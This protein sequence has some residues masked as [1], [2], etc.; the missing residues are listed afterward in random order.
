MTV[1]K[2]K[3][4]AKNGEIKEGVLMAGSKKEAGEELKDKQL[5]PLFVQKLD[6]KEGKKNLPLFSQHISLIEKANLCR[7]LSTMINS[8]L[9][10]PEAVEVIASE[11]THPLMEKILDDVRA[12]LQ[13]GQPLSSAFSKY[14]DV[15]DEVFLTLIKAGEE[16]GTLGKSFDYLGKQLYADYELTSKVKSTLA[17]PTVIVCASMGLGVAMLVFVVPQIAP[18]L[19]NLNKEFPLPFYTLLILQTGLFISQKILFFLGILVFLAIML[20][21][22]FRKPAGRRALGNFFSRTPFFGQLFTKL[23]LGRFSR[24]LATLLKSGVPIISS[25]RVA[26]STLT[27]PQFKNLTSIFVGEVEKG[28]SLSETL[29]K[30][31][32]FPPMMTRMVST[33]EKTGSLDKLLLELAQFYEE[34]VSNA[35]KTLT[36]VIEPI[37]MLI[38]GIGVGVMV[39]SV[40][41]PIYSF[42]GSLSKSLTTH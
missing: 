40:I 11:T 21:L 41:A 20:F 23:V 35:L 18:I 1:F 10:L 30:T 29:K 27:L 32:L 16:S 4:K 9:P 24:T 7:Y 5:S 13:S 36:S 6:G 33:G 34:E 31:R 15:F 37:L 22:F 39:V 14:P 42:V 28:V 19:L 2:Y 8:G 17:Y 3:A 38:I 25:L 12:G 26:A